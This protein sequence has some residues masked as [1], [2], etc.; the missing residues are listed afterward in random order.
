[1]NRI[2]PV[3]LTSDLYDAHLHL[4]DP[5]FSNNLPDILQ[6][7]AAKGIRGCVTNGTGQHDWEKVL[8]L[9][10]AYPWVR[11]AIGVH[12][13]WSASLGQDWYQHWIDLLDSHPGCLIGE[14]GFDLAMRDPDINKQNLAF[15]LQIKAA[16][17]RGIPASIH[18][19]QAW[20][21][22]YEEM[23]PFLPSTSGFL[24]HS[25]NGPSESVPKW[26]E[27]GAYFSISAQ[28]AASSS[29]SRIHQL[30]RI[31]EERLLIETDAP[32]RPPPDEWTAH[33]LFDPR[34]RKRIHHPA[35]LPSTLIVLSNV[36]DRNPQE[37]ASQIASNYHT[38]FGETAPRDPS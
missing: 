18:C 11:P 8:S 10:S 2:L 12:P 38:L 9:A 15:R 5:R 25:F 13:W 27:A 37:L 35:D 24:L 30:K 3:E 33:P 21:E 22:L 20:N 26:N 7:M 4:T 28:G 29:P 34:T 14:I 16:A 31:P 1:M 6:T 23:K 17:E 32:N 19:V 36:L